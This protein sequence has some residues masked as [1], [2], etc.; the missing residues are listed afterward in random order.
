[1]LKYDITCKSDCSEM[2]EW[3]RPVCED[4]EEAQNAPEDTMETRAINVERMFGPSTPRRCS[5][6]ASS[7][8][9]FSETRRRIANRRSESKLDHVTASDIDPLQ[10]LL[11]EAK[12]F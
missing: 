6:P 10:E 1:M 12:L 8:Q 3:V 7:K 11:R 5:A 4:V 9:G 2:L